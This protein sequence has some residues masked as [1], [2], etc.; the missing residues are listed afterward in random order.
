MSA[1]VNELNVLIAQDLRIRPEEV[2]L[3]LIREWR[4]KHKGSYVAINPHGGHIVEGLQVLEPS[5]ELDALEEADRMAAG[6][7]A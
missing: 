4:D 1:L 3:E 6:A 5:E 2:T 7:G